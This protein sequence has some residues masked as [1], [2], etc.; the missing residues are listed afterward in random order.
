MGV[1]NGRENICHGLGR[2][3]VMFIASFAAIIPAEIFNAKAQR[4]KEKSSKP[5]HLNDFAL[6]LA[7]QFGH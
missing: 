3:I 6:N 7:R 4:R 1:F 2:M 5:W